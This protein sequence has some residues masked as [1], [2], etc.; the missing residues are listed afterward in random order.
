MDDARRTR[1]P[2][3]PSRPVAVIAVLA[4]VLAPVAGFALYARSTPA[5]PSIGI[6]D[7]ELDGGTLSRAR[8][9]AL[10]PLVRSHLR[11]DLPLIL[12]YGIGL[13]DRRLAAAR[14]RA[15]GDRPQRR[16]VRS[17]GGLRHRAGRPGG[18]R[19]SVGR[20]PRRRTRRLGRLRRRGDG[21]GGQVLRP[22]ARSAGPGGGRAGDRGPP[23]GVGGGTGTP[24]PSRTATGTR[25]CRCCPT[26]PA[27]SG[28]PPRRSR[29][30]SRPAG[31]GAT[32]CPSAA[33][34]G[35]ACTTGPPASACRGAASGR[36]AWPWAPCSPRS[37]APRSCR[38]RSTSSPCR[39]A[40]TPPGRSSRPSPRPA[41]CSPT[42]RSS[43]PR[44]PRSTP[45]RRR[46]TT[47]AGTPAI[48]R[49]TRSRSWWR[50]RWSPATSCSAWCCCSPPRSS[51]ASPRGCST[52]TCRSWRWGR[53]RWRPAAQGRVRPR[54]RTR[55]RPPCRGWRCWSSSRSSPG[56]SRR[57]PVRTCSTNRRR[58]C[59]PA[60]GPR[61]GC[62]RRSRSSRLPWSSPSRP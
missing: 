43:G 10:A 37:S 40:A 27:R 4:A 62:W 55:G 35:T 11:W 56:W 54:T 30:P 53:R 44:R 20:L 51:P 2:R 48:S 59:A 24:S 29:Q 34:A 16:A 19:R 28:A 7:V 32:R 6:V 57:R 23:G 33:A 15:F 12:L 26:T 39:A 50:S 42:R 61:R 52:G 36:R 60:R 46:R 31:G 14:R 49:R 3:A 22:G 45:A 17:G 13:V 21:V 18:G 58:G 38:G 25:R 47:S 9:A 8:V 1:T 41:R 5:L